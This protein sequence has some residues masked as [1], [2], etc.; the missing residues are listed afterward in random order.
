M[1]SRLNHIPEKDPSM[2]RD[3]SY[4]LMRR[5]F[6]IRALWANARKYDLCRSEV[7]ADVT[8]TT[9]R[10]NVS[11]LS[12]ALLSFHRESAVA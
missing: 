11:S 1:A 10:T 6:D 3:K 2:A 5:H 8:M 9:S 12:A 4:V 7:L